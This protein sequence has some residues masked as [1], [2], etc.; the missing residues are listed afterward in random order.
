[1]MAGLLDFLVGGRAE[2]YPFETRII[3]EVKSRLDNDGASRLQRQVEVINKIQRL[4]DGKEVNLYQMRHGKPAFDDSLRFP[5][6]TDE[7]LLASVS[8]TGPDKRTKLKAEV[9]LA[10]GRL[11]SLVFN[12]PPKQFFA[13]AN[14]KSVQPEIAT[15]KIWFDP[16]HPQPI[17]SDKPI[18]ESTLTG[19]LRD[20]HA[21][22][23]TAG[24][25]A[26][27]PQSERSTCLDRIDAQ[28]PTDYL[29]LV[30]QTEGVRLAAC[31]VYGVAGI[32]QIVWTE[33]NYYILAEI[34]MLGALAVKD[35]D[36]DAELYLLH[37]E[38]NDVRPV[39]TSL[40]KAVAS[41]LKLD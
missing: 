21:K 10:N 39:G 14:L 22:G 9:W 15:V 41:L 12:K 5:G 40:Q 25:H 18:D 26:P 27:L 38:D 2:F 1:M 4:T 37:Y 33:A 20:W 24:L 8:L 16:M 17:D 31:V 19:W 32:R 30:A 29:E 7:A 13:G 6:A 34:E 23:R 28:L 36:R 3:E 35:G 11:F